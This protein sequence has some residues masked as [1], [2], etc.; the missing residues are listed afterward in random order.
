[1]TKSKS[2]ISEYWTKWN[3]ATKM[4]T[5]NFFRYS[6]I[7]ILHYFSIINPLLFH[8]LQYLVMIRT[9]VLF[10]VVKELFLDQKFLFWQIE[11]DTYHHQLFFNLEKKMSKKLHDISPN[12]RVYGM[13]T[14]LLQHIF[15]KSIYFIMWLF[16]WDFLVFDA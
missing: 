6:V 15:Y 11:L 16:E 5:N 9:L 13:M 3:I 14:W 8:S 1:M 2:C 4:N 10:C 12:K 7:N